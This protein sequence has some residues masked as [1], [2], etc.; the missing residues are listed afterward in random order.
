MRYFCTVNRMAEIGRA[1][2]TMERYGVTGM[3]IHHWWKRQMVLWRAIWDF[4]TKL[5]ILLPCDQ[6]IAVLGFTQL[7]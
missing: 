2:K 5:N 4:L 7:I 6:A 1:D 3:P